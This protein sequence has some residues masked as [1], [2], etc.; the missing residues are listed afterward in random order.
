MRTSITKYATAATTRTTVI[1]LDNL[2]DV[3]TLIVQT[4]ALLASNL[5]TRHEKY[6][7]VAVIGQAN[8]R[9]SYA[10]TA[11][12]AQFSVSTE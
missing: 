4:A 5:Q 3:I 10:G 6:H 1:S 2:A 9:E 7:A 8:G 11:E 12:A